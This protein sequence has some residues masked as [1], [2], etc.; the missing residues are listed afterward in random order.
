MSE[1]SGP[2]PRPHC[3]RCDKPEV[4]C[5]CARIPQ[6]QNRTPI[7]IVQHKRESR[8]PLGTVRIA[9]LGLQNCSVRV[10]PGNARSGSALPEWLPASAGLLYPGPESRGLDEVP[11]EERPSSLVV[12]DGTWHQAR[13]LFRDHAWLR[14]LPRFRLDPTE[15]ARYRIRREPRPNYRSTIEAIVQALEILEPELA[16]RGLIQAFDGLIDDQIER[17]QKRRGRA[18]RKR[19]LRPFG[20]RKMP[21]A[22]VEGF[23]RLLLAYGEAARP[24]SD[25]DGPTELVHW[26]ALRLSDGATFDAVLRPSGGVPSDVRLRHLG[27]GASDV[28]AGISLTELKQRWLDFIRP[29]DL[30]S[31][32][33]VRTLDLFAGCMELEPRGIGLKSVYR[34]MRGV[35]GNLEN[36]LD[37]EA[38]AELP[39]TWQAGLAAVRG[40]ARLRLSNA[41]RIVF[42]LRQIALGG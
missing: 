28:E 23:D 8:H 37:R 9:D 27:L 24:E 6:V 13:A 14:E 21:V 34:R 39:E 7:V 32:W 2:T 3:Y 4:A 22:L 17:G 10:V 18:P 16:V 25:P 19:E 26:T 35:D 1:T 41:L 29:D 33:N 30:L 20:V 5:L 12:I 42:F 36:V 31:A 38:A 11:V 40:R 15:A